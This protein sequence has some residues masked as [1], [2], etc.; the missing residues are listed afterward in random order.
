MVEICALASG[1]NGNC[2][3]IGNE[4]EAVIVDIGISNRQLNK[5][6]REVGLNIGKIKA[7]FITHEH[8]DHV[9]GLH[10]IT[11]RNNIQAFATKKTFNRCR[12]DYQSSTINYIEADEIVSVGNIKV[13]SFSKKHDASDPVSFRVEIE[14]KNIAVLTDLGIVDQTIFKHVELCDAAFLESNYEHDVLMNGKYPLFLKNRVASDKGH[15]SNT[16][17]FELVD[18]LPNGR[19]K[20]VVLSHISADNN[21]ID[22]ATK[23]F[24]PV[25]DKIAIIK[26]SRYGPSEVISLS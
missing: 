12:K 4:N 18:S 5:R 10:S 23:A 26:T 17:A 7:V 20:T 13:H 1:S 21:T 14:D 8:T 24:E 25:A 2:Y 22:L 6:M 9:K 16:Q 3:Y 11:S 19:L 15:L